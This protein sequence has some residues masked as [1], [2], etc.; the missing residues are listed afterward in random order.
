MLK[1]NNN[2]LTC[3]SAQL[4]IRYKSNKSNALLNCQQLQAACMHV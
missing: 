4:M 2:T 3:Q 1:L